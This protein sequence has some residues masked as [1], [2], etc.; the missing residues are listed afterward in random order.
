MAL[1]AAVEWVEK[2][3]TAS[4][5][6]GVTAIDCCQP[7]IC[8]IEITPNHTK[9]ELIYSKALKKALPND[10]TLKFN[11]YCCKTNFCWQ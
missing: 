11:N 4:E 6:N 2:A 7:F 3:V 10:K 5:S 9:E 1:L 8:F